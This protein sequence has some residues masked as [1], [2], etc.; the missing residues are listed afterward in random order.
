[1]PDLWFFPIQA[2]EAAQTVDS[3]YI[4]LL[5]LMGFF[6]VGVA[7][8]ILVFLF[9]Y[10]RGGNPS[11]R[12]A[13]RGNLL[14]EGV[15]IVIPTLLAVGI[16]IWSMSVYIS[17]QAMPESGMD[18]YVVGKQWMWKVQYPNGKREINSLHVPAGRT[19]RLQMTSQD[20]IHSMYLP[21]FRVK[22]DV[23]PGR[24]T[25]LS[26]TATKPGTY[27]LFCAEYCGTDHANMRGTVTVMEPGA[28]QEWLGD[29]EPTQ[30]LAE[31]GRE[32]F[33]D[34]GCASCHDPDTAVD[35]P[36]LIELFSRKVELRSGR[37]VTADT[38][39][40][41]KSILM[42]NAQIVSGFEPIMPSFQGQLSEEE[43]ID[44]IAYIKSMPEQ[45]TIE[46]RGPVEGPT[47]LGDQTPE[48]RETLDE[49][50]QQQQDDQRDD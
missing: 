31:S 17:L 41:R 6:L 44:L 39:Y 48:E 9:Y 1:M 12:H 8:T 50:I 26:F 35:A 36:R 25:T 47:D 29:E 27:H 32:L 14:V 33:K 30:T 13:S 37:V 49:E 21:A 40:I 45:Q 10:R 38:N 19:V 11:R 4:G 18:V 43:I 16:F 23:L 46:P 7:G 20:V 24:F 42:P 2:S 5:W 15:W 28:Y 3:L 34:K 22:Q